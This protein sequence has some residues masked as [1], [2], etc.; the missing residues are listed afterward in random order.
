MT[1]SLVSLFPWPRHSFFSRLINGHPAGMELCMDSTTLC[2][3]L[4]GNLVTIA[5]CLTCQQ[6]QPALNCLCNI[7]IS[8]L[9][10]HNNYHKISSLQQRM[11]MN[12]EFLWNV[13][14]NMGQLSPLYK[15][16]LLHQHFIIRLYSPDCPIETQWNHIDN[17]V[18]KVKIGE[19]YFNNVL[20][21]VKSI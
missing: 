21:L 19:V 5:K 7:S 12:S 8:F 3:L 4:K 15:F 20:Y 14:L 2:S 1:V 18:T 16:Q 10:L 13:S 9:L 17:C 6:Q 11:F